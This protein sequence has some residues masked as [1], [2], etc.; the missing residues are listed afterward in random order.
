MLVRKASGE[1]EEFQPNKIRRTLLRAGASKRLADEIIETVSKKVYD[2]MK[3]DEIMDMACEL[4]AENDPCSACRYG[5]KTA[6]MRLGPTGYPFETFIG[7]LLKKHGYKVKLRQYVRGLCVKHEIDVVATKPSADGEK[8]FMIEC[9][10]RNTRGQHIEIKEV[11]VTYARFLDIVEGWEKGKGKQFDEVWLI[12][13]AKA[14]R[15]S[16]KYAKC[17]GIALVCWNYPENGSL[18]DM[19]E[20]KNLYPITVLRTVDE[21][22]IGRFSDLGIM[23]LRDLL[24]QDKMEMEQATGLSGDNIERIFR[25][26]EMIL[27]KKSSGS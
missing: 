27:E 22:T 25:E 16:K 7:E 17:R 23:F 26:A 24:E 2:G 15:A 13:N 12:S 6:I 21:V 10:Y 18:R 20:Q 1:M 14:S 5:L 9:K 11:L 3:T 4:L 8:R 19:I